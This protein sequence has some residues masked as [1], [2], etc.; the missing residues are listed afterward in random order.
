MDIMAEITAFSAVLQARGYREA[1]IRHY[2]GYVR[3][4]LRW[5]EQQ[6]GAQGRRPNEKD[7]QAFLIDLASSNSYASTTYNIAFNSVRHYLID[8]CGM[9]HPRLGLK[10]QRRRARPRRVLS[11]SSVASVLACVKGHRH[12]TALTLMYALG[13]RLGEVCKIRLCDLEPG[14]GMLVVACGKGGGGRRLPLPDTC[15]HL[16]RDYWRRWRPVDWFFTADG[17]PDSKPISR[18]AVQR[19]FR[20]A[21]QESGLPIQGSTHLL[22]HSFACHQLA[23]GCD[24]R[25]LQVVLGHAHLNTTITYLGDLDA[26]LGSRPAMVDLLPGLPQTGVAS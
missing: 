6:P 11:P 22:R 9:D 12:R 17:R 8:C 16:L 3:R 1:T 20:L 19:A 21:V 2:R 10:P 26:L 18:D 23:A 7:V 4:M 5:L 15:R 13:L 14:T 25:S 24:I